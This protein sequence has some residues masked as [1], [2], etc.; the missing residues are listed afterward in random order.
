MRKPLLITLLGAAVTAGLTGAGLMWWREVQA[1]LVAPVDL[2]QTGFVGSATCRSCHADHHASWSR[3]YH[4]TMTQEASAKSVQGAFDG[5]IV[6]AWGGAIRPVQRDG[7]YF[8]DLLD[9]RTEEVRAS[10]EILR[11]VGSHRYQQYLTQRADNGQYIRLQMLWHMGDQRWVHMNGAF[12]YDDRQGF[13]QH[14]TTWNHNCIYCHNTGPAPGIQNSEA[15]YARAARGE[16][17]NFLREAAYDSE[18]AELGIACESCHGP[19]AAH[20][21]ANRDPLRRY[22]LHAGDAADPSITNPRRLDAPRATYIC[23]QCHAQRVP[24]RPD[25]VETW[26]KTGPTFR[27]GD[28]LAEHVRWITPDEPGPPNNPDLYRQ[29]FWADGTPRLSAYEFQGLAQS[30]CYQQAPLSCLNCHDAHGGDPSGMMKD[31]ARGN[32]PCA[33]CHAPIAQNLKAHTRHEPDSSGSLCI[34]CHM[35]KMV[36][37]VMEIHRSHHIEVPK[38]LQHAQQ[39]RPDACTGCHLDRSA[40][41]ADQRIAD[42]PPAAEDGGIPENLRQLLGGDPVQRAVA[43]KLA[44]RSDS[45]LSPEQRLRLIPPLLL[46]MEDAYPAVRRFAWQSLGAIA[47][48]AGL[49]WDAAAAGFDFTGPAHERA[50]VIAE[51]R[52]R[53]QSDAVTQAQRGAEPAPDLVAALRQRAA[54]TAAINIGE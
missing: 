14:T 42:A 10:H 43:A 6:R 50:Q 27:A 22:A 49:D 4:R 13:D 37:G 15:L 44:G 54:Q 24:V 26:L 45:A 46:A 28:D 20:A 36:Y 5:Q 35:P 18:V 11:T 41:W 21:Q 33:A 2:H 53:W 48:D 47:R 51:L 9:P 34:N 16:P 38:P 7:K 30:P 23:A 31:G 1:S 25:L 52:R 17:V 12:L 29:R 8:F 39:E 32:A 40:A 19:G 3:T